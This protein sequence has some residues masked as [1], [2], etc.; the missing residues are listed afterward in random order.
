MAKMDQLFVKYPPQCEL[1]SL[2]NI[3]NDWTYRFGPSGVQKE[4]RDT[5]VEYCV[6]AKDINDAIDKACR[7]RNAQ[8]KMHN[9]QSRVPEAYRRNLA[10]KIKR[11]WWVNDENP[12]VENFDDLYDLVNRCRFSGIGP[13]TIYDV[14]TRIAAFMKMEVQS[15]YLHAGVRIGWQYLIGRKDKRERVPRAELPHLLKRVTTDEIE[16]MMC[17]YRDQL[18]EIAK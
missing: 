11:A 8:G 5:V 18:K 13:V 3:V 4:R 17:A 1:T 6:G 10:Q 12:S 9:H 15:L 7:S 16:D 14:A 2:E